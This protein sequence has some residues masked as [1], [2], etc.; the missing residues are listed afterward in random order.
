MYDC[1]M[2]SSKQMKVRHISGSNVCRL[3]AD[4][5]QGLG[6]EC[7]VRPWLGPGLATLDKARA[8]GMITAGIRKRAQAACLGHRQSASIVRG[9][10]SRSGAPDVMGGRNGRRMGLVR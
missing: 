3:D 2:L 4:E 8:Y 1:T 5:R 9:N 7:A 10:S 6:K